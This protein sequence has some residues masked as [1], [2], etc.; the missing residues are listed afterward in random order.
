MTITTEEKNKV[1]VEIKTPAFYSMNHS[2]YKICEDGV[3]VVNDRL[4]CFH[5]KGGYKFDEM[6]SGILEGREVTELAFTEAVS[7][8]L[9][10]LTRYANTF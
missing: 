4:V 10:T 8:T 1:R 6:V 2:V 7:K 9:T 5:T 3:V